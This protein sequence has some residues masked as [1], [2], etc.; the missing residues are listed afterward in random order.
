M[1]T[2]SKGNR[3]ERQVAN[4]LEDAGWRTHKKVN[5]TYDS[6]DAFGLFDVL[7]LRKGD[8]PVY[9]QVKSNRTAGALKQISEAEFVDPQ[10]IDPQVWVAHDRQGFRVQRLCDSGWQVVV[11][12]RDSDSNFGEMAVELFSQ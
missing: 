6:G 11:D 9:I 7:A 4:L 2:R 3:R 1:S 10:F 12:E 5:N 8:R